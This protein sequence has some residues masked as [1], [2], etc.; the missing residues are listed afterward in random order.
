MVNGGK[1]RRMAQ[2]GSKR[3][4]VLYVLELYYS[5]V[6]ECLDFI[7]K[8]PT[9]YD[10]LVNNVDTDDGELNDIR[11]HFK[12]KHLYHQPPNQFDWDAHITMVIKK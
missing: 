3:H 11:Q 10:F 5:V 2:K 9:T 12:E 1:G 4:N 6:A 8:L 7:D